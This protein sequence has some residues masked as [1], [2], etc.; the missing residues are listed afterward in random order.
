M[1]SCYKMFQQSKVSNVIREVCN[2]ESV[3]RRSDI[4]KEVDEKFKLHPMYPKTNE[5]KE[6]FESNL[7]EFY[8]SVKSRH[9]YTDPLVVSEKIKKL[10][11]QKDD[12][13]VKI[14]EE[15]TNLQA[16]KK[17]YESNKECKDH[18][19]KIFQLLNEKRTL[20][21]SDIRFNADKVSPGFICII[22]EIV[23]ELFENGFKLAVED[24]RKTVYNR[25]L[26][27]ERVRSLNYY[28]IYSNMTAFKEYSEISKKEL[29][30][31]AIKRKAKDKKEVKEFKA[32]YKFEESAKYFQTGVYKIW[33][34]VIGG[35][36]DTSDQSYRLSSDAK[37]SVAVF[38]YNLC[39]HLIKGTKTILDSEERMTIKVKHI[40]T[41]A[42]IIG[43][44]HGV[45]MSHIDSKLAK[46]DP[47]KV[48]DEEK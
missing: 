1:I 23:Y 27:S 5:N 29:E 14:K 30:H 12:S 3:K 35:G 16:A 20:S 31:I 19:E 43:E 40:R 21:S 4:E 48:K 17:F 26:F 24:K 46:I 2:P 32:E 9:G 36:D 41:L 47:P 42:K 11:E 6:E 38:A 28:P 34:E 25:D 18:E 33:K 37:S 15:Q 45:D 39:L 7:K 13:S 8:K 10:Q 22:K 44:I